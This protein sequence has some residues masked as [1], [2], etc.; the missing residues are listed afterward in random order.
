MLAVTR[1]SVLALIVCG[2]SPALHAAVGRTPGSFGVSA[3][4]QAEYSIPLFTPT[5]SAK[6]TPQLS[7]VYGHR[8]GDGYFGVGWNLS[9]LSM[10]ARCPSTWAQNGVGRDVRNDLQDRFCLDGGQ[11]RLTNGTY[12]VAGSQYRTEI[13][14]FSRVTAYGSAGNGPA[15]FIVEQKDGLISSTG[16]LPTPA[17]SLSGNRPPSPGSS[18]RSATAPEM[19]SY[20]T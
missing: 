5:G 16:I 12:A 2:F 17:S 4:G 9:G 1:L 6:L 15:Y 10:I 19:R 3:T 20:L 14:T 7:L 13:E 11:L 18:T 8:A